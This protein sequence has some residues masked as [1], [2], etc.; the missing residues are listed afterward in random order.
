M[1]TILLTVFAFTLFYIGIATRLVS[2]IKM[3]VFQGL[4]LFAITFIELKDLNWINLVLILLETIVFKTI[5]IPYFLSYLIKKNKIIRE[6]EPF[7][8]NFW[9]LLII[10]GLFLLSFILS[11]V[12]DFDK[13]SKI[14]VIVSFSTLLTGLYIIISRKKV[15][16]HV[17]GYLVLEN[18]VFILSLAVGSHQPMLVNLGVL[19]DVFVSVL[20]FGIFINQIGN[21]FEEMNAEN[22]SN[23]KD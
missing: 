17:M 9:S 1:I 23:L 20:V 6:A 12:L 11:G 16:T 7:V 8:S 13:Q 21:T 4:L 22:L 5:A 3:L 2:Y 10:T 18:G 15:I 19:L 14:F